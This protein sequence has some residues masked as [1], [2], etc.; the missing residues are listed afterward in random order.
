[1]VTE[2]PGKD[3]TMGGRRQRLKGKANEAG[4]ARTAAKKATP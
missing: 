3:D 4:K 2:A 1:M